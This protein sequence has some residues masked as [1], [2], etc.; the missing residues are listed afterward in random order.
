M[1]MFHYRAACQVLKGGEL[2]ALDGALVRETTGVGH[3][4][5]LHIKAKWS[6]LFQVT[7]QCA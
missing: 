2:G 7:V 1:H 5:K 6:K 3:I 4:H